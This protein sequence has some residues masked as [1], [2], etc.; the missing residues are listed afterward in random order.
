MLPSFIAYDWEDGD[1]VFF[2]ATTLSEFIDE[3]LLVWKFELIAHGLQVRC[4]AAAAPVACI[5]WILRLIPC[6]MRARALSLSPLGL[7]EIRLARS[8]SSSP[9]ES[10]GTW[11]RTTGFS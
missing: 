2:D 7:L 11:E 9:A 6:G 10:G 4:C 3:A 8:S 1:V 5:H